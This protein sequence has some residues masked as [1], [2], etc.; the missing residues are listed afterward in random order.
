ME[1]KMAYFWS[2]IIASC[3][4][5]G[6]SWVKRTLACSSV[7]YSYEPTASVRHVPPSFGVRAC[8]PNPLIN[9]GYVHTIFFFLVGKKI[10]PSKM[11]R[12]STEKANQA[13]RKL[14][15]GRHDGPF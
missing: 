12:A 1:I 13:Q 2:A 14:S 7:Q 8:M 15:S 11:L 4:T 9:S 3:V 5:L 10:F 6:L